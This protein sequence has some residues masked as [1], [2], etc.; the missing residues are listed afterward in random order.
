MQCQLF[1]GNALYRVASWQGSWDSLVTTYSASIH[2]SSRK[3]IYYWEIKS[4]VQFYVNGEENKVKH[5]LARAYLSFL[6]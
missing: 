6:F 2:L 4:S 5:R 1:L 3:V